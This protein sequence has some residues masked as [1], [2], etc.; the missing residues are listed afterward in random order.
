MDTASS[1]GLIKT[2]VYLII[3]YYVVKFLARLFFPIVVRKVVSKAE[4]SFKQQYQS[5]QQNY[6][7]NPQPN[8]SVKDEIILETG[9]S[10]NPKS[11]KKVGEYVDYE[12]I[13]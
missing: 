12:E 13:E 2:I 7:N 9:K 3:A 11:T 10:N 5:A 1:T 6:N 4:E 8:R